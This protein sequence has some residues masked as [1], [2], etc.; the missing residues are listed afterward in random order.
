MLL[1]IREVYSRKLRQ[2]YTT[3]VLRKEVYHLSTFSEENL[4]ITLQFSRRSPQKLTSWILMLSFRRFVKDLQRLQRPLVLLVIP[5]EP[6]MMLRPQWMKQ[7][8]KLCLYWNNSDELKLPCLFF[9]PIV[10]AIPV[11][12]FIRLVVATIPMDGLSRNGWP[13][14][15]A[16]HGCTSWIFVFPVLMKALTYSQQST[17]SGN[18]IA[19]KSNAFFHNIMVHFCY[20]FFK[21]WE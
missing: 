4:F 12:V 20:V 16:F 11:D 7:V 9:V 19:S 6:R 17:T 18:Y 8:G 21:M 1:T 14:G 3:I 2:T 5:T 10:S 13:P 15:L